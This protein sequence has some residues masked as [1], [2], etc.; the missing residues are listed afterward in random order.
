MSFGSAAERGSKTASGQN[1][2]WLLLPGQDQAKLQHGERRPHMRCG[3]EYAQP[4]NHTEFLPPTLTSFRGP[5]MLAGRTFSARND[6]AQACRFQAS[7]PCCLAATRL[8][9]RHCRSTK[10]WPHFSLL[11]HCIS[12]QFLTRSQSGISA[13]CGTALQLY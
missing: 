9:A 2:P 10:Y 11:P 7:V 8:R 1:A 4:Q 6:A 13:S 3:R 5:A 12:E